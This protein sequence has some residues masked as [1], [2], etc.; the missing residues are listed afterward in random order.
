[1]EERG[2]TNEGIS[3]FGLVMAAP[4]RDEKLQAWNFPVSLSEHWETFN[5]FLQFAWLVCMDDSHL[6]LDSTGLSQG[7]ASLI[8]PQQNAESLIIKNGLDENVII[9]LLTEQIALSSC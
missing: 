2:W 7:D 4:N 3:D 1:M 9:P 6:D 8:F 5:L